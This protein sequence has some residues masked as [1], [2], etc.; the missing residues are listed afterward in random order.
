M[1]TASWTITVK[2]NINGVPTNLTSCRLYDPTGAFGIKRTDNGAIVVP[3]GTALSHDGIGVYSYDATG[4]T[5]GAEYQAYVE[6]VYKGIT[7]RSAITKIITEEV[8]AAEIAPTCPVNEVTPSEACPK[9]WPVLLL[10]QNIVQTLTVM[11]VD[12]DNI[13]V[14]VQEEPDDP[15]TSSGSNPLVIAFSD[16]VISGTTSAVLWIKQHP[17]DPQT[18]EVTGT[19]QGG[20]VFSFDFSKDSVRRPGLYNASILLLNSSND[21]IYAKNCFLEIE[22]NATDC[23]GYNYPLTISE[24][25]LALRDTCAEANY[26]L[27]DVEFSNREIQYAI[28][29]PVDMFNETQPA[30]V[31]Y[32]YNDFPYRYN[33]TEATIGF[34]LETAAYNLSR[35]QLQVSAA[36]VT[37]N[38]KA[39][40]Q[41][42]LEMSREKKTE[43]RRWATQEQ[44]RE[45][46]KRGFGRTTGRW[47]K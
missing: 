28:H 5:L 3:A 40:W 43:F 27:D 33:W 19:Y 1:S 29:R 34:L 9:D 35:N 16:A 22:Q 37:V 10:K 25:R 4:L 45:N 31:R 38:D 11:L 17:S 36:G 18:V 7:K 26:L 46:I 13:P 47:C 6:T 12:N 24:I 21:P 2:H 42:Y 15:V 8:S 23:T 20:G 32:N 30:I 41:I 44:V 39:R 14:T